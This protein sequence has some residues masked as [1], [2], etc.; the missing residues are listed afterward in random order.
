M[1]PGERMTP[2]RAG[3][4]PLAPPPAP[5]VAALPLPDTEMGRLVRDTDWER[6]GLGAPETWPEVLRTTVTLCLSSRFPMFIWWGPDLIMFYNDAYRPMLGVSK[7]PEALGRPGR[8]VWPEVWEII[9]P[10]VDEVLAGHGATWFDDL[11]V[12]VDRNGYPE[13][14]FFTFS[15]GPIT[16]EDG[17]VRGVLCAC[18]ETTRNVLTERRVRTRA[19]LAAALA[20]ATDHEDVRTRVLSVLGANA[21]DHSSVDLVW[22]AHLPADLPSDT[23]VIDV[24]EPGGSAPSAHLVLRENPSRPWDASLHLHARLSAAHIAS[25]LRGLRRLD[26]ERE[27]AAALAELDAAKTDFFTNI[28][29][30]LRTPI[31]LVSG[32]IR[33]VLDAESDA[34][35]A[36][37][38]RQLELADRSAERLRV[39]VDELLDLT[40]LDAGAVR[41]HRVPTDVTAAVK[42][43]ASTFEPAVVRAGLS[44]EVRCAEASREV[45]VDPDMLER[46]VLNLLSNAL[47]YTVEGSIQVA[48]AEGEDGVT[49][50]VTDTGVGIA[51]EDRAR[52]FDRFHQLPRQGGVRARQGGGIGLAL[53]RQLAELHGGRATVESSSGVGSTFTVFL[54]WGESELD[55]A[56]SDAPTITPRSVAS[57]VHEVET[58]GDDP[59][60]STSPRRAAAPPEK[61]PGLLLVEDS[62]D[63]RAYL[64]G[65]LEAEYEVETAPD[66]AVALERARTHRPEIILADVMMPGLDGL[67]LVRALRNDETLHDVPI[68]LIS[69]RAGAEA[70]ESGLAEGA[71]DY[72]VKPFA[73]RELL[74]RLRANLSR[75]RARSRDGQWQRAVLGALHDP[76]LIMTTDGRVIEINDAF[77]REFGWSLAACPID[78]P[79]P[80]WVDAAEDGDEHARSAERLDRLRPGLEFREEDCRIRRLDGTDAWV[81]VSASSVPATDEHPGFILG[82]VRDRTR[83]RESQVR[84]ALAARLAVELAKA[85][86]LEA[87]VSSA[88]TGF[89]VLFAGAATVRVAAAGRDLVLT[90]DGPVTLDEL[91]ASA[92]ESLSRRAP[93]GPGDRLS[94]AAAVSTDTLLDQGPGRRE[95]ILLAP[96]SQESDCRAWV[97]FQ[98]PR[99]VAPDELIVGDLLAQLFAQ[100]VDR[101]VARR[102]QAD[103]DV[104]FERAVES[105]RLIGQAVGILIERHRVTAT[106]AFEMLRRASTNRNI[107]LRAIA[108]KVIATGAEPEDA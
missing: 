19:D 36:P 75:S 28:S 97:L 83:E 47:K 98:V 7:H 37:T 24:V 1:P 76:M 35:P 45:H 8:E 39:L 56:G 64:V 34:I 101:V 41:P 43:L 96:D 26:A 52:V 46:I 86:D 48:V 68:V 23:H 25:A 91:D 4:L 106:Q 105:H 42:A 94:A 49:I 61:R 60:I 20:D 11:G 55:G 59:E 74:A 2:D 38:R 14:A 108:E 9:G 78:P 89:S 102:D 63:M 107:K 31:T 100:A 103:R 51:E 85:H 40:R 95:G 53:V 18:T 44:L 57:F 82:T 71:D 66:G 58:W 93:D 79:Y 3:D 88:V 65:L 10:L 73:S 32:P 69:A 50:S 104:H 6:T 84:R 81:S 62:D 92:R 87:V 15:H 5:D 33:D 99:A 70:S 12:V 80:W 67:G 17:R 13:E 90:P 22:P 29:H 72:V 16:D 27:R 54:P 77:T 30:E 21:G